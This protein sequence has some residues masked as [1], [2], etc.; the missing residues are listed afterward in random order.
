ME[1]RSALPALELDPDQIKQAFYNIVKNSIQA[2]PESGE[3]TVKTDLSD[4]HI[5]VTF[6]D[7]GEGIS[8]ENLS[9]VFQPYFTTKK[10]G[11]GL[12][13]AIV[14]KIISDHNSLIAF[15]SITNGAKVEI[16]L[17]IKNNVN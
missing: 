11:T 7:T 17:P 9:T 10:K 3:I 15:N 5:L 4:N 12:G 13:L 8:A 14:T 16:N 2:T 6:N 1:L